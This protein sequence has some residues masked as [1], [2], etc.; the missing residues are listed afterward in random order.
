M[1]AQGTFEQ[2]M[3]FVSCGQLDNA[4]KLWYGLGKRERHWFTLWLPVYYDK[5]TVEKVFKALYI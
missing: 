2:I 3:D 4:L 5:E 1:N